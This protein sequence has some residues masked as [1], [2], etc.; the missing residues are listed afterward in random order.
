MKF[1]SLNNKEVRLEIVPAHY[2]VRTRAQCKSAGQYNLGR[3]I[4]NIYGVSALLLEEFS[5][6]DERLF[7][8]FYLPHHNLA[9]EFHGAQHDRFH[10]FFHADKQGFEKSVAR[11]D[12][13]RAW[14]ILNKIVLVE[15]RDENISAE[16][17]QKL[18]QEALDE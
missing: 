4:Q 6:P 14:C 2:P 3:Q 17:L 18:I 8:D 9:F 15:V 10:K 7:L 1:K 13:K 11:D 12:R 16:D 5:I